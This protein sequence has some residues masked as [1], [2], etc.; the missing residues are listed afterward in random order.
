MQVVAEEPD[1]NS[2]TCGK[3]LAAGGLGAILVG[4][5][6]PQVGNAG[7]PNLVAP[8]EQAGADAVHAIAEAVG[9]NRGLVGDPVAIG[10]KEHA[11]AIVT[12]A[13]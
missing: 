13:V 8:G 2:I 4:F 12:F 10:V 3:R 9:E 1:M 5:H 6:L 11:H 7:E